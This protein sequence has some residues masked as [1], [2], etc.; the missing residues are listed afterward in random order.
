LTKKDISWGDVTKLSSMRGLPEELDSFHQ[1]LLEI[2]I[3]EPYG[4]V[5]VLIT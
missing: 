5:P 2:P 4:G 1:L 3:Y